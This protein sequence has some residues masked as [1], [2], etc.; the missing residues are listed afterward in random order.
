MKKLSK[1]LSVLLMIFLASC[2]SQKTTVS[3]ASPEEVLAAI[4]KQAFQ[5]DS[6]FVQ[7][8]RGRSLNITGNYFLRVTPEKIVAD[9]PYFGRA[10]SAPIGSEGGIKFESSDFE[11]DVRTTGKGGKEIRIKIN[12]SAVVREMT[13]TTFGNGNADLRVTP[14]NKQFISYRGEVRPLE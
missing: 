4:D 14:A 10:Y 6:R 9:L 2:A 1:I 5:F 11:Y 8:A 13:L 7:P 12:N 3:Q